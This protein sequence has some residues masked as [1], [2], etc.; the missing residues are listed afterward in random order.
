MLGAQDIISG[1]YVINAAKQDAYGCDTTA[2]AAAAGLVTIDTPLPV[3]TPQNSPFE[4][5]T[6]ATNVLAVEV[7]QVCKTLKKGFLNRFPFT[8]AA[9][10]TRFCVGSGIL[11]LVGCEG[12]CMKAHHS[13]LCRSSLPQLQRSEHAVSSDAGGWTAITTIIITHIPQQSCHPGQPQ[14]RKLPCNEGHAPKE[15]PSGPVSRSRPVCG[16][17]RHS[18]WRQPCLLLCS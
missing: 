13:L 4:K 6:P 10:W 12:R 2:L 3:K 18:R 16:Q 15:P 5:P 9:I 8:S 11:I 7:T 17:W 1:G 14:R